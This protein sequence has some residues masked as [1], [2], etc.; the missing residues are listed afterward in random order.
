MRKMLLIGLGVFAASCLLSTAPAHAIDICGNGFCAND[1]IETCSTCPED[2]GTCP[3]DSDGDGV[4]DAWDNCPNTSNSNQA[5]C[6]GDGVGDVCDSENADY[7]VVTS[8]IGTCWIEG[9]DGSYVIRHKEA[10]YEDQSSCG[11]PDEWR[12]YNKTTRVC[13]GLDVY[14]CCAN[15]FGR[16]CGSYLFN[17]TCQY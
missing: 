4:D 8:S 14:T 2:C 16:E 9:F 17:N 10:R 12:L 1:G 5:D 15:S 6:D 11:A 3:V 13:F 7:Q